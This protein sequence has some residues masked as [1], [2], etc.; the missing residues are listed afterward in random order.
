MSIDGLFEEGGGSERSHDGE[1]AQ[2][3]CP[4]ALVEC[5]MSAVNALVDQ[6]RR[7]GVLDPA[8]WLAKNASYLETLERSCPIRGANQASLRLFNVVALEDLPTSFG[9][10]FGARRTEL[11]RALVLARWR[12]ERTF[13]FRTGISPSP[14]R[15]ISV[16]LHMRPMAGDEYGWSRVACVL[17]ETSETSA[18]GANDGER[19]SA[20][21]VEFFA[22]AGRELRTPLNAVLGIAQVLEADELTAGQREYVE[23]VKSGGRQ[24]LAVLDDLTELAHLS[25]GQ[26]AL[27]EG[28]V[29]LC[30]FARAAEHAWRG[31]VEAAGLSFVVSNSSPDARARFDQSRALRIVDLLIAN[32]LNNT[33]RG[34]ITLQLGLNEDQFELTV[35]DTGSGFASE[36]LA[37]LWDG[38]ELDADSLAGFGGLGPALA[39]RLARAMGGD[40]VGRSTPGAGTM[41][42]AM[43]HA[44]PSEPYA[45]ADDDVAAADAPPRP[46]VLAAEDNP[47]S[48][49]VLGAMLAALDVDVD[50]ADDGEAAVR[51]AQARHYDLI[52]MDVVLPRLDGVEAAKRIRSG[53]GASAS[54]PIIAVTTDTRPNDRRRLVAAGMND[55]V[56]KPIDGAALAR[57]VTR[58]LEPDADAA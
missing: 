52:F 46:R 7:N 32:A 21:Q 17:L 36:A 23:L 58:W 38:G 24:A 18:A 35:A 28:D 22:A 2:P 1:D 48:Q 25:A 30:A 19:L 11:Y 43:I 9:S 49:R 15:T 4:F 51:R 53:E 26:V 14:D 34:G 6:L 47:L 56:P 45:E 44:R 57:A 37:S 39:L 5:D 16:L 54:A 3:Y 27:E 12:G 20:K 50:F 31:R 33:S 29:E 8:E 42:T 55:I 40:L 41:L 13:E 10:L